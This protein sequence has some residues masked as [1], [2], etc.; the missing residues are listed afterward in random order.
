M[1]SLPTFDQVATLPIL[2]KGSV[3]PD[4]ITAIGHMH[5]RH[6]LEIGVDCSHLLCNDAGVTQG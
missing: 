2:A 5:I 3:T 6:Y 1:T 4:F